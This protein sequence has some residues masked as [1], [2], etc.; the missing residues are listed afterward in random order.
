LEV[1]LTLLNPPDKSRHLTTSRKRASRR[2]ISPSLSQ[3]GNILAQFYDTSV[4]IFREISYPQVLKF[5][6]SFGKFFTP[7]PLGRCLLLFIYWGVILTMLWS[8][9]IL[10]PDSALYAYKWE[11]VGF[12]A[13]W[14]SVTQLP[15]IYCLSC[16][17][18]LISI[19]TG[20]SYERLNWLHR[21]VARTFFLT[22]VVHWS[23]FYQEW[24][25][26]HFVDFE[27]AMMP[28]VKYGFGAWGVISWMVLS[29]FGFFR[30]AQYEIFVLQHL[31]SAGTLLWLVYVHVP[32]YAVY[33]IWLAIGFLAFDWTG[34][35]VWIIYRNFH[36]PMWS[37]KS[38]GGGKPWLGYEARLTPVSGDFTRVT[39]SNID[40]SW[41]PGQ[42]I[43]LS[44]PFLGFVENHPFTIADDAR[45]FVGGK[46]K[47]IE[48]YIKAHSGFTRRLLREA[49]SPRRTNKAGLLRAFVSG[50]W[51]SPPSVDGFETV[52][53]ISSSSGASFT[54]PIFQDVSRNPF[55]VRRLYFYWIIRDAGQLC[56]FTDAILGAISSAESHGVEVAVGIFVT[57]GVNLVPLPLTTTD[58][59]SIP[60][61]DTER[62][63]QCNHRLHS[64]AAPS[65]L[66][67]SVDQE[68]G[69]LQSTLDPSAVAPSASSASSSSSHSS[70]LCSHPAVCISCGCRPLLETLVRPAVE[71]AHGETAI[72]G[73]GGM[74][75]NA[76][77]RNYVSG[78]SDER[79]VH[80]GTGAQGLFLFTETYG[81]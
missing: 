75:F 79:A 42:H 38:L 26:A 62:R 64:N 5:S 60:S 20:I 16:K 46:A 21:W 15:L 39:I 81:W 9:V 6:G 47:S 13:A 33:N 18:N 24:T 35:L 68:K 80:K 61:A 54:V 76:D 45:S 55:C 1:Y 58:A 56:W 43:Y 29:S 28:M 48:L 74:G 27:M 66:F 73:C 49:E 23:F 63:G 25:I 8:N 57:Q 37:G 44:I 14:V 78:L 67:S 40:F 51:G 77:L 30:A 53:L 3:P 70:C 50:P 69:A 65:N 59:S 2:R 36:L 22:V 41:K 72:V 11:I 71:V 19:I 34:R 10:T 52:V 12:R 31:A 4:A 32:S 17:I 7:P